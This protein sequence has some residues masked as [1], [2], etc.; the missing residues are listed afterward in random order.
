VTPADSLK[1]EFIHLHGYWTD[2]LERA[3]AADSD[4]FAAYIEF[5]ATPIRSG[6][7]DAKTRE[8]ILVA[9]NISITH[10]NEAATSI[11]MENAL[12]LGATRQEIREVLELVSV[13]GIHGYMLGAPI[14]MDE[15]RATG[16]KGSSEMMAKATATKQRF[17]ESRGYWSELL[18]DM[19]SLAPDF[20]DAYGRYSSVPFRNG[21]LAPKVRELI[22]V[23]IDASATH[24]HAEG[25]RIHMKNALRH[26][27]SPG[28]IAEVLQLVSTLGFQS[29]VVGSRL[30]DALPP[31]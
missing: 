8:L 25:T 21:T 15:L 3:L 14:L 5:S 10:L 2:G 22:Y 7:L 20:F 4:F 19:V 26:G 13:L 30:L 9:A 12:R 23:A 16:H 11:H 18:E 31:G 6:A 29:W 17:A 24:L 27:A 1:A 28:E